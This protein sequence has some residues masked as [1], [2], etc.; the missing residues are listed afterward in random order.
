[1]ENCKASRYAGYEAYLNSKTPVVTFKHKVSEGE[2]KKYL[3]MERYEGGEW[4]STHGIPEWHR[5]FRFAM[6]AIKNSENLQET[7]EDLDSV[8]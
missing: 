7:L 6:E 5:D 8:L 3:S 2:G 4:V 1:M